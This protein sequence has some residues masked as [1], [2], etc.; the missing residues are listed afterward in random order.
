MSYNS[1]KVTLNRADLVYSALL[2]VLV[3]VDLCLVN[4]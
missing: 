2:L 3:C 1:F 4:P